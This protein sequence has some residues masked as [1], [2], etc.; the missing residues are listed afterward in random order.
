VN[1][2]LILAHQ[3]P[4]EL[5]VARSED[6]G[7]SWTDVKVRDINGR[8]YIF[9]IA[10]FDA[11]GTAY[12]VWSEDTEAP[13]VA[14]PIVEPGRIVGIPTVY[15]AVSHDKGLTWNEPIAL[16]SPGVAGLF[17]WIAA[18]KAGRV[19]IVWY[20]GQQPTPAN[21]LP[22]V[23]DV[24]MAMSTT[25]DM[26]EPT[27]VIAQVNSD[28]VH[29]GPFCTEGSACSLT[30]GDRSMLDFFEVRL[31]PEGRPV[32]AWTG[33]DTVKMERVKVFASVMDTGTL[34]L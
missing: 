27:F 25:A 7:A 23:F 19:A 4:G 32:L 30:G 3:L 5:Y 15:L 28:P 31:T 34:L 22:N 2:T 14:A 8:P 20:E 12:L 17:P 21:R 1:D 33:D 10:A 18:G 24:K 9:P 29:V 16:S 26:D 6:R 11:A 13:N